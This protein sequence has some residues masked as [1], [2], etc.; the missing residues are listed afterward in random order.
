MNEASKVEALR[1]ASRKMVRELGI[2]DLDKNLAG[3][4]PQHCHALIEIGNEPGVTVSA[5][6]ELLLMSVSAASRLATNLMERGYV[7]TQDTV[8]RR[9][10]GL[11][12]TKAGKAELK[13]ID[14]FSNAKVE[15]AFKLLKHEDQK[16]ILVAIQKYGQA[17]E[18]SRKVESNVKILTLSTSRALRRQIVAMVENIQNNEFELNVDP[19][20]N[21]GVLKAEED[22]YYE[23]SY[24]FWY[25]VDEQGTVVGSIGL[26]KIDAQNGELKKFFVAKAH[27]GKGV[28]QKLFGALLKAAEKHG[29]QK[30]WLGTVDEFAAAHKFYEKC[31]FRR[32]SAKTLPRDFQ[33]CGVDTVFFT[34]SLEELRH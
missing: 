12:L 32:I 31:G 25:A 27:R 2:I 15:G 14:E 8:D 3:P 29:F 28:A 23:N 18:D 21:S 22:F 5:L 10:K 34:A 9:Q 17:L 1:Q 20:I 30:L 33:K 19:K 4:T 16:A 24:N 7:E 6:S 11:S 26:K 13:K